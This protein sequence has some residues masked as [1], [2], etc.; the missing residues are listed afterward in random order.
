MVCRSVLICTCL[1]MFLFVWD[2]CALRHVAL[3]TPDQTRPVTPRLLQHLPP[4]PHQVKQTNKCFTEVLYNLPLQ[5]MLYFTGLVSFLS[6]D[7]APMTVEIFAILF[8]CFLLLMLAVGVGCVY[9]MFDRHQGVCLRMS[10]K[11]KADR[12]HVTYV[13]LN[14]H[15]SF[16]P[17]LTTTLVHPSKFFSVGTSEGLLLS[18]SHQPVHRCAVQLQV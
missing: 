7:S 18:N 9:Q 1:L 2:L 16:I 11:K 10:K 15:V 5:F 6:T 13:F 4:K 12:K 3:F 14:I 17:Q 8:C